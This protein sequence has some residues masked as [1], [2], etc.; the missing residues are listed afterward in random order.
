MERVAAEIRCDDVPHATLQR[1]LNDV[2]LEMR[3]DGV[4]GLDDGILA[5]ERGRKGRDVPEIGSLDGDRVGEVVGRDGVVCQ[6]LA[7]LDR[8]GEAGGD[9]G[10]DDGPADGAGCLYCG[11]GAVSAMAVFNARWQGFQKERL[12]LRT[13]TFWISL[14]LAGMSMKRL[15]TSLDDNSTGKARLR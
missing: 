2:D 1:R 7:G 14:I 8:Y 11:N 3:C 6:R 15:A 10:G 12:T 13:I 9:E 4:E 5:G